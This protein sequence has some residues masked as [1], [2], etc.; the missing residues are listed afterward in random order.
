MVAGKQVSKKV[1]LHTKD[2]KLAKLIAIKLL[3]GLTTTVTQDP[4]NFEVSITASG[5][6]IKTDPTD[7]T[8]AD[9][10]SEF[11]RNNRDLITMMAQQASPTVQ[12]NP[13]E[14]VRQERAIAE[15]LIKEEDGTNIDVVIDK[16]S[17]RKKDQLAPKTLY[18]YLQ[19]VKIFCDWYK[20]QYSKEKIIISS[21]D[22]K[23]IA[24]YIDYLQKEDINNVTIEKNYLRALNGIFEF[25]KTTGDYPD[26]P[27]PSK[28]HKL[29]T[30]KQIEKNQ[31]ERNPYTDEDLLV[32]FDPVNLN[33]V[34][35]PE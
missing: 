20:K 29:T 18:G 33:K 16:Y 27:V 5:I 15:Q 1:S 10:L 11:M 34:K 31:K 21:I 35:H 8:D 14:K 17:N 7:P 32:I 30:K 19:Y 26:V 24:K 2:P 28:G 3:A 13:F 23:I 12:S 9:K 4:K 22:K 25:A 6:S